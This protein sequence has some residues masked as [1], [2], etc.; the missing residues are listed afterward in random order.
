MNKKDV[1]NKIKELTG[2]D[3]EKANTI[4][5]ILENNLIVGKHGKEK[6]T[7]ELMERLSI[8]E[9]EADKIYNTCMSIITSGVKDKI[10]NPFKSQ[11]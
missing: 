2:F 6:I 10:L 3:D 5:D 1:I 4:N 8:R 7:S 9:E 11:N